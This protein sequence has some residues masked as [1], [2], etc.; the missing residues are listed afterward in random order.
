[1]GISLNGTERAVVSSLNIPPCFPTLGETCYFFA[2]LVAMGAFF[3]K[4]LNF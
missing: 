2:D 4:F 1:V 3:S